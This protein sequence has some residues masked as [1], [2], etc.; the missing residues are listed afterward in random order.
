MSA[1]IYH[2]AVESMD[3]MQ[4]LGKQNHQR[5]GQNLLKINGIMEVD[6]LW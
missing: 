4:P 6:T 2:V 3:F 5:V 1:G